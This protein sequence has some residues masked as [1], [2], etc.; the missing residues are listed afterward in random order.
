M[1]YKLMTLLEL[2]KDGLKEEDKKLSHNW[3]FKNPTM[4]L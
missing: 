4:K 3:I 1:E 2:I